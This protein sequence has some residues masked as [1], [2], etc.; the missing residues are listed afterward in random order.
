MDEEKLWEM[1]RR[2]EEWGCAE[3]RARYEAQK[4]VKELEEELAHW[5]QEAYEWKATVETL[6]DPLSREILLGSW[7][8]DD[9]IEAKRPGGDPAKLD[10][11]ANKRLDEVWDDP[12]FREIVGDEDA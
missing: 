2:A 5:K 11:E 7:S 4:R 10:E 12:T 3:A 8:D 9:F 1:L 6:E